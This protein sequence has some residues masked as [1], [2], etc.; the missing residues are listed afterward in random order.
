[1][2]TPRSFSEAIITPHIN[3]L[4]L[5]DT[6]QSIYFHRNYWL[7]NS[8]ALLKSS[9]TNKSEGLFVRYRGTTE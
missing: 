5:D 2:V 7:L 1:M 6:H 3:Q 4:K 9:P 8:S